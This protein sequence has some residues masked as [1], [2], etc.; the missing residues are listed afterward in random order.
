MMRNRNFSIW[1]PNNRLNRKHKDCNKKKKKFYCS[2]YPNICNAWLFAVIV[3]A[4]MVRFTYA[5][6]YSERHENY[7]E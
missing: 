6:L 4:P 3:N 5:G 7:I 2:K 1:S